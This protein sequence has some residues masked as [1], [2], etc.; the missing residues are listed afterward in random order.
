MWEVVAYTRQLSDEPVVMTRTLFSIAHS[1]FSAQHSG[2]AFQIPFSL[3]GPTPAPSSQKLSRCQLCPLIL[4]D[5]QC[6]LFYL[7][8]G[9]YPCM[10]IHACMDDA[11]S[12]A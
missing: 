6:S 11:N 4:L 8:F 5:V 10:R 1:P 2:P 12:L 7:Y 9:R 3:S